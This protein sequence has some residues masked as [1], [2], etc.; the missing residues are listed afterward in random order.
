[1]VA[2]SRIDQKPLINDKK[3]PTPGGK[4]PL[5]DVKISQTESYDIE[6]RRIWL[7]KAGHDERNNVVHK[8]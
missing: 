4:K 3:G 1:M 5:R 6:K 7:G 8:R 2:I